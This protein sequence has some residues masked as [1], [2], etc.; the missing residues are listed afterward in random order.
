MIG[1]FGFK[2]GY[3]NHPN[4]HTETPSHVKPPKN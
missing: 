3:L 1:R 2:Q 4:A